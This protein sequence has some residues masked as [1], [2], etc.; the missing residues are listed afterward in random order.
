MDQALAISSL[1]VSLLSIASVI[2]LA[3]VKLARMEVKVDTMWAFQL[4]R[5]MSETV[6][7]GF[8]TLN[9]PLIF[10]PEYFVHLDPIKEELQLNAKNE[11]AK[12]DD[13]D[14]L[15]AIERSYGDRLLNLT[16][17]PC[18][19]SHGA[20]LLLALCVARGCATLDI[21]FKHTTKQ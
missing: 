8:G 19:L 11:W 7:K 17:L 13:A 3:G 18:G 4:R 1:I 5:S 9:S 10:K 6:E 16:C 15:L 20:C 21:Q 2:Y 14:T 12:L